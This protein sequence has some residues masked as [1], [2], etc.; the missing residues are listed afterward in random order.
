MESDL[1]YLDV[2]CRYILIYIASVVLLIVCHCLSA[3]PDIAY[4][5]P[6]RKTGRQGLL[7]LQRLNPYRQWNFVEVGH[8]HLINSV[9][10]SL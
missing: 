10:F 3:R 4:D 9:S 2:I 6:D 8:L 7:E 1:F 5:V